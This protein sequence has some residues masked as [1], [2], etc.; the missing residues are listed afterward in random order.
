[1]SYVFIC[2]FISLGGKPGHAAR[3]AHKLIVVRRL[4]SKIKQ[5]P[6]NI[7]EKWLCVV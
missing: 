6:E 3:T 4:N 2:V 7:E 5:T 1:M